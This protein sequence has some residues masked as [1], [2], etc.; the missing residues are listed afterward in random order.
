M[1]PDL[2]GL[3]PSIIS[4]A[5]ED[6]DFRARLLAS[7]RAAVEA[8]TGSQLP[9]EVEICVVEETPRKVVLVLPADPA[10]ATGLEDAD[11]DI[12]GGEI[13]LSTVCP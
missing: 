2:P 4:R 1:N 7:P 8:L 6:P 13:P 5:L 12:L 10:A 11:L 9:E 3:S